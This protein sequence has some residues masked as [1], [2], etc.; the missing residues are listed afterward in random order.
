MNGPAL[1]LDLIEERQEPPA[2]AILPAP[3][4]KT[5]LVSVVVDA[6]ESVDWPKKSQRFSING[7][8]SYSAERLMHLLTYAYAIGLYG[9][10][11]IELAV[12]TDP[13]LCYLC[14]SEVPDW[15]T[16]RRFRRLHRQYLREC[17][18]KVA[19]QA[20]VIRFGNEA[21]ETPLVD[22]CVAQA[23][24]RWFEPLCLPEP[25]RQADSRIE[26]AAFIDE[27]TLID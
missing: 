12:Q 1:N 18:I 3:S 7:H 6:V 19:E 4:E 16:L 23:L 14:A 11:D 5:G 17:L 22:H 25:P 24:D 20:L 13:V 9:S 10:Q 27:M 26:Q 15:N 2:I 21:E 8:S